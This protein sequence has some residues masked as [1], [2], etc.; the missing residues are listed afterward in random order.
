MQLAFDCTLVSP[1][2]CDGIPRPGAAHI[3]GVALQVAR[4]RTKRTYLDF[5]GHRTR[6][7]FVVLAGEVGGR[8]FGETRTFVRLLAKAKARS[9]P[10][11]L[12]T[13]VELAWLDVLLAA[14]CWVFDNVAWTV[15]P[16]S[17][18]MLSASGATLAELVA[19]S[20]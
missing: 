3:D 17:L 15:T 7:R 6:S 10:S 19:T 11:I 2:H 20:T 9:E 14:L 1:S 16:R 8:C 5:T 18:M 4:R 12:R 13:R